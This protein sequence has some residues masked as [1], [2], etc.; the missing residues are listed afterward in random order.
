MLDFYLS[1]NN[2]EE[3]L[4]IP[5]TPSSFSVTSS[6]GTEDFE[7]A[8]YGWIKIIG[9][10]ELKTVSWDGIFPVHD[11]NFRRDSTMNG[12]EYF[13][14]LE[15]WRNRKLPVRLVITSSGLANVNINMAV[16]IETLDFE[17]GT[18]GDLDYSITLGE[19][20]LLNSEEDIMAQT[21]EILSRLDDI[22]S[23]LNNIENSMVYNYMDENMPEWAK[24]TLQKLIDC[25]ALNG[26]GENEL[27][28]TLDIIRTL[29]ICDKAHEEGVW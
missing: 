23:R 2:S 12:Q 16:A 8:G 22:E 29:V 15:T 27:G 28:L 10:K 6:Q 9:N 14:K 21:D 3:V 18:N 24:A 11:Y 19:V 13:D 25:G 20:D 1:I 26:T 4:H 7:S 17:V 5:V